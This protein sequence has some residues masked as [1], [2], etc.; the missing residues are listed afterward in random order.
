[1]INMLF[2]LPHEARMAHVVWEKNKKAIYILGDNKA[3]EQK[4]NNVVGQGQ[5]APERGRKEL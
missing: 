5:V 2:V 3:E 1:M 4:I